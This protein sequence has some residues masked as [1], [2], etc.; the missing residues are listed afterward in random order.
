MTSKQASNKRK[1]NQRDRKREGGDF[2]I[3]EPLEYPV[4][5]NGQFF[6]S[7]CGANELNEQTENAD[8]GRFFKC[9]VYLPL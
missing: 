2:F 1:I 6:V 8:I 5:E 7:N 9:V 3:L 4:I